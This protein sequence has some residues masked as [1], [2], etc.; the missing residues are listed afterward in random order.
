MFRVIGTFK[1]QLANR[2]HPLPE[3]GSLH[4]FHRSSGSEE[5][6]RGPN[7]IV[8]RR[9]RVLCCHRDF[10]SHFFCVGARAGPQ[11]NDFIPGSRK[12]LGKSLARSI[13]TIEDLGSDRKQVDKPRPGVVPSGQQV[14][15]AGNAALSWRHTCEPPSAPPAT[16]QN[17]EQSVGT[18]QVR[19]LVWRYR[20]I[21][22][23]RLIL[24]FAGLLGYSAAKG[25]AA[26]SRL[27]GAAPFQKARLA[28]SFR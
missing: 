1:A 16:Q 6:I 23:W 3:G 11:T 9:I 12:R 21:N 28:R 15:D 17:P 10:F 24:E 27:H 22:C 7:L 2:I 20:T 13:R 5:R 14:L 26:R 19:P 4:E 25:L 18:P 8:K